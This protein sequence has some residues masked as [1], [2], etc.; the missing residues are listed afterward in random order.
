MTG[1]HRQDIQAVHDAAVSLVAQLRAALDL[2]APPTLPDPNEGAL[3]RFI[4]K[5]RQ[6][7]I[8]C[9]ARVGIG[10]RDRG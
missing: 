7:K 1:P 3:E 5:D 9:G 4:G 2:D 10:G 6:A 8:G